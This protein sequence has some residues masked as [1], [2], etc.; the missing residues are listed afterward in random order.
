[1]VREQ[2]GQQ[3]P[4]RTGRLALAQRALQVVGLLLRPELV[5]GGRLRIAPR[6]PR[7]VVAAR[8]RLVA[9]REDPAVE[10]DAVETQSSSL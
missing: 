7:A 4:R 1:M 10:R 5:G 9:Q 2:V 8:D 6:P 3:M